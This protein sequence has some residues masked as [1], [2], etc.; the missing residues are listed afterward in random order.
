MSKKWHSNLGF[1]ASVVGAAVGLGSIWK[2]P[3]SI[4]ENGG[5]AFL[6]SYI[7]FTIAFGIPLFLCEYVIGQ[8]YHKNMVETIGAI[9]SPAR[10]V[11]SPLK[12]LGHWGNFTMLLIMAFYSVV[13]GWCLYYLYI[14]LS[15]S[16]SFNDPN[17][18]EFIWDNLMNS[19]FFMTL[20]HSIFIGLTGI[21]VIAGVNKGIE[22]SSLVL[23]PI[24]FLVLIGLVLNSMDFASFQDA[25][26]F[27][28][29]FDKVGDMRSILIDALGQA[30][31]GLAVGAGCICTYTAYLQGKHNPLNLTLIISGLNLLVPILVVLA[32][33]PALIENGIDLTSG[34]KLVFSAYPLAIS[35]FANAPILIP[36]VFF[37]LVLAAL[38]SAISLVEPA[39]AYLCERVKLSRN[40]SS[41]L[42]LIFCWV[43]GEIC[44]LTFHSKTH[45]FDVI[46][47]IST[48]YMLPLGAIGFAF[49]VGW[50]V[51]IEKS[52]DILK[53]SPLSYKIWLF[54]VRIVLPIAIFTIML[55]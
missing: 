36:S 47:A 52:R 26:N 50:I 43:L 46:V 45:I 25:L 19:S 40:I 53:L 55:I 6:L 13:S 10:K 3:Y 38:T 20:G 54:Q 1:V 48:N 42:V 29:S 14:S 8:Y 21:I 16:I 35:N 44:I 51:P 17:A 24:L 15:S 30:L 12:Y 28:I 2:F 31:F 11:F 27:M 39:I 33:F 4:G 34:P 7:I 23:M 41:L 49:V 18:V 22:N 5:G 37:L 32:I 9:V